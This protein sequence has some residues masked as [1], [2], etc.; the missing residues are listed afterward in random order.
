MNADLRGDLTADLLRDLETPAGAGA[1]ADASSGPRSTP[2]LSLTLT[3]LQWSWP[4]VRRVEAGAGLVVR[5]GP[6][7]V[8]LTV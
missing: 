7:R 5:L 1:A 2:A 6:W 4:V 8:A 3:P